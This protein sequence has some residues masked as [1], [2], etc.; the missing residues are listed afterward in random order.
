MTAVVVAR[1][2]QLAGARVAA[3]TFADLHPGA[4]ALLVVADGG[5]GGPDI[6]P[7]I[8]TLDLDLGPIA[9]AALA[10]APDPVGFVAPWALSAALDRGARAAVLLGARQWVLGGLDELAAPARSRGLAVVGT[11]DPG[12]APEAAAG[13]LTPPRV[14]GAP[15]VAAAGYAGR[16]SL[17]WWKRAL[18]AGA[19]PA[20]V[21]ELLPVT[22]GA[23]VVH[24][25]GLVVR[26][27]APPSD[28]AYTAAGY[29]TG[30]GLVGVADLSG[31]DAGDVPPGGVVAD[32]LWEYAR[33]LYA[34]G[35]PPAEGAPV[36]GPPD[37]A[38]VR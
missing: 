36:L 13:A 27:A 10:G 4:A 15:I 31:A 3:R 38:G 35:R 8:G 21:P 12:L 30:D 11:L 33:R 25:A 23:A 14:H 34:D 16:A 2:S 1:A 20:D 28:L 26:A 6:A 7:S 29:A 22:A 9:R 37:P 32:L 5:L 18:L 17:R 24:R 19:T